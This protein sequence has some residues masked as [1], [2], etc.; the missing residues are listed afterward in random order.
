[1]GVRGPAL[2]KGGSEVGCPGQGSFRVASLLG[3]LSTWKR[4]S[5]PRGRPPRAPWDERVPLP[6][7]RRAARPQ[8]GL[9]SPHSPPLCR[10]KVVEGSLTH[11]FAL[12]LSGDTLYWTDWQTRS[13]HACNKRTGEKRKEILSALYSPMDIQVLSQERQPSCECRP[14]GGGQRGPPS[15]GS[16]RVALRSRPGLFP[17]G[18]HAGGSVSPG[19]L[20]GW[21]EG[22]WSWAGGGGGGPW[23]AHVGLLP[24]SKGAV[25]FPEAPRGICGRVR[26]KLV[27]LS[28][29]LRRVTCGAS[30]DQEGGAWADLGTPSRGAQGGWA[31]GW[32]LVR[33]ARPWSPA[34]LALP[35]FSAHVGGPSPCSQAVVGSAVSGS[36][37]H[38]SPGQRGSQEHLLSSVCPLLQKGLG[39]RRAWLPRR[40]PQA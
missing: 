35:A 9:A 13:I 22:A 38:P 36:R 17:C 2:R 39:R 16:R 40:L 7:L 29:M 34:A 32:P 21:R 3:L 8:P 30:G 5:V 12:T 33:T 11:P 23:R 20:L 26:P 6:P 19:P 27:A 15:L 31:P 4:S 37:A 14:R 24:G 28:L 18:S 10:Q 1:M 25:G